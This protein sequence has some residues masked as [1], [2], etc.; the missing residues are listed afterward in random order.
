MSGHGPSSSFFQ[1]KLKI[2]STSKL[3]LAFKP[4]KTIRHS[5]FSIKSKVSPEKQVYQVPCWDCDR[6]CVYETI[7]IRTSTSQEHT[8]AVTRYDGNNGIAVHVHGNQKHIDSD[9]ATFTSSELLYWKCRVNEAIWI[10]NCGLTLGHSWL[11]VL[12]FLH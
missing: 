4:I 1:K 11:P 3:R 7:R 8:Q 12:N 6:V 9:D 5:L 10:R 2:L